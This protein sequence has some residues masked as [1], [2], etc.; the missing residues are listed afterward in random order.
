MT[1]V[2]AD[3][4]QIELVV[5]AHLSGDTE[6]CAAF[7]SGQ[8]VHRRTAALIFGI[9]EDSVDAASRRIAKT[10]NFGVMYGM[11]A[12]RLSNELGISRTEAQSFIDA[13]FRTYSGVRSYMRSPYCRNRK[14]RLCHHPSGAAALYPCH[15]ICQ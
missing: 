3:Y 2:S 7:K 15:P 12:F 11:S 1:L 6:L 13:Y 10:I 9:D 14:L 5:L 8:D 4:N